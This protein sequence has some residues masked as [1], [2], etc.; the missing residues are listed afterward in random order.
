MSSIVD[1]GA[2]EHLLRGRDGAEPHQVRLDAGVREAD[3][4][5]L[6][7]EAELGR[8]RLGDAMSAAVAPSVRPA[9]FPAVTRPPAR[10]GVRSV[11]SAS[12]RRVRAEE[13]VAV[14]DR[15]A[16][17]GEHRHRDDDLV[18][19]AVVPRLAGASLRLDRVRVGG[20]LRQVRERV[21][22]VLG[23]LAHDGRRLVDEPLG[24]EAR[25]EVDVGAHRVVAH[26]LDAADEH[27]VGGAHRDLPGAGGRR[28]QRSRAHAVDGEPGHRLAGARRGARRRVRASSPWSPTCA[29]AAKTT[30]SIRSGGSWGLRRSSSRTALTAMSSARVFAKKPSGVARPNAVRT[31]ST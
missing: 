24:D 23:R 25:V 2:S 4:A 8:C 14:G 26:V 3:E 6:R 1:P 21:V 10:N 22:E 27:D 13:L 7:L 30:S 11:A 16:V 9:E 19:H 20:L 28:R 18:H 5:H 15:P 17:V 29:V 31:P 12:M